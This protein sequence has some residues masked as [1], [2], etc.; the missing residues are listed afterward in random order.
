M[1]T[2]RPI[3]PPISRPPA[4]INVTYLLCWRPERRRRQMPWRQGGQRFA[5][6]WC[7]VIKFL[8]KRKWQISSETI[9]TYETT[10]RQWCGRLMTCVIREVGEPYHFH[11]ERGSGLQQ[12]TETL[13]DC[14]S[15]DLR[16]SS[17]TFL[18]ACGVS[19]FDITDSFD[20]L[21][22]FGPRKSTNSF[23]YC[24]TVHLLA[25][26]IPDLSMTPRT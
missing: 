3:A 2:P 25:F 7:P 1:T 17:W 26:Q 16:S 19:A 6:S 20:W 12:M 15:R 8:I 23:E 10:L 9:H 22:F 18:Q 11:A 21:Q 24:L 13:Q 4:V 5:S 14:R